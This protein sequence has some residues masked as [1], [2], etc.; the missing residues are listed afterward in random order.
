MQN[1]T[2]RESHGGTTHRSTHQPSIS[3]R[4]K[5][6]LPLSPERRASIALRNEARLIRRIEQLEWQFKFAIAAWA[7]VHSPDHR[8]NYVDVYDDRTH[9]LAREEMALSAEEE[10]MASNLNMWS[11]ALLLAVQMNVALDKIQPDHFDRPVEQLRA[12][13]IIVRLVRHA[14]AHNPLEPT[15][16]VRANLLDQVFIV[17]GIITLDTHGIQGSHVNPWRLGPSSFLR[18]AQWLRTGYRS[19]IPSADRPA[20]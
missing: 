1:S 4:S 20:A 7:T 14:F 17:P 8:L 6:V 16:K 12:A 19:P 2:G 3:W 10:E 15:W 13:Q 9:T 5:W 18:L 11:A